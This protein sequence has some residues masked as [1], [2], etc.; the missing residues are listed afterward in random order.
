M[1]D[2]AEP[3][4]GLFLEVTLR[5]VPGGTFDAYAGCENAGAET[6][7]CAM[8]GDAGAFQ[9]TPARNGGI[10]VAVS[11]LGMGFENDD[12]FA[13]LEAKSGD[14]RSFILRPQDCR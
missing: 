14:D 4:L 3:L 10:L 2:Y 11:R 5:G 8:E 13:T 12:G 9:I 6:L 1:L 7:Y